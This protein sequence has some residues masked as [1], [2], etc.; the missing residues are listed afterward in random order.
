MVGS[1]VSIIGAY[2]EGES[3]FGT[4]IWS[5]QLPSIN[6]DLHT[7]LIVGVKRWTP[8]FETILLNDNKRKIVGLI[9]AAI[10][11]SWIDSNQS[12]V[13]YIVTEGLGA[14]SMSELLGNILNQFSNRMVSIFPETKVY[15]GATRPRIICSGVIELSSPMIKNSVRLL[16]A[17]YLGIY[18]TVV[19][20][21]ADRIESDEPNYVSVKTESGELVSAPIQNI[22]RL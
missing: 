4:F 2:G 20:P 6:T 19:E 21:Q 7:P 18:G 5:D 17:P 12:K 9:A 13:S 10:P 15:A 22:E 1:G 11:T 8:A 16:R 3:T 14:F